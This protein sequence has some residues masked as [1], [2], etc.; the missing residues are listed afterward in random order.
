MVGLGSEF[1]VKSEGTD[2]RRILI[3]DAMRRKR[4]VSNGH[5][6]FGGFAVM[7]AQGKSVFADC[8]LGLKSNVLQDNRITHKS[9][10]F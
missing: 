5:K 4:V 7:S 3:A 9:R 1:P 2:I 6:V 10:H 8:T